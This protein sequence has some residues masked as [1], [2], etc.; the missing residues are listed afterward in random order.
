MSD[1]KKCRIC[2]EDINEKAKKCIHCESYQR[3]F[4]S[5][6]NVGNA[7]LALVVALVSVLS[8]IIP[9]LYSH[10]EKKNSDLA[11]HLQSFS[12]ANSMNANVVVTN[13]GNRGGTIADPWLICSLSRD[14]GQKKQRFEFVDASKSIVNA[15]SISVITLKF[16]HDK[17]NEIAPIGWKCVIELTLVNF[18]STRE[19]TYLKVGRMQ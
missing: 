5:F 12:R 2:A 8:I 18:D 1:I 4:R 11:V 9:P 15:E 17:F 13:G 10:Y 14:D 3:G 6:I 16:N 19:V 7:T